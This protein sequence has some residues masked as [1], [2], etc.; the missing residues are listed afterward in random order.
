MSAVTGVTH[1]PQAFAHSP[2]I[3]V[4]RMETSNG[5]CVGCLRTLDEIAT[6]SHASNDDRLAILA[7]IERRRID[8]APWGSASEDDLG[9]DYAF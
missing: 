2:C 8:F 6:W 7:A 3:N 9:V 5:L 4:C 1:K